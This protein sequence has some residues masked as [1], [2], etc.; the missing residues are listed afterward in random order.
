MAETVQL[1]EVSML[2][3]DLLAARL[4]AVDLE[5]K[6]AVI[7][8]RDAREK[9]AQ[10]VREEGELMDKIAAKHGLGSIHSFKLV[11]R[12]TRMCTVEPKQG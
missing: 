8:V 10:L 4:R 3:V 6:L 7:A 12:K 9:R 5:E 2:E 11:D 1:D